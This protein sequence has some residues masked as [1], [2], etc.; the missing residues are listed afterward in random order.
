MRKREVKTKPLLEGLCLL[1]RHQSFHVMN[2]LGR[3]SCDFKIFFHK[4]QLFA[5]P[6]IKNNHKAWKFRTNMKSKSIKN[7][8]KQEQRLCKRG[9]YN[10]VFASFKSV[11]M[12]RSKIWLWLERI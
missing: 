12:L 7:V 5:N 6:F 11:F 3:A 8:T 9:V 10:P 2:I 1:K 4:L